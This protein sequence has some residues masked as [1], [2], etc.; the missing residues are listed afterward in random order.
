MARMRPDVR[1][2]LSS[3]SAEHR[4]DD[5]RGDT[6]HAARQA[7][8]RVAKNTRA[9][10]S[11]PIPRTRRREAPRPILP[12]DARRQLVP[13]PQRADGVGTGVAIH[14][15]TKTNATRS[16]PKRRDGPGARQL[17]QGHQRL[18]E[19]HV[20]WPNASRFAERLAAIA[21]SSTVIVAKT[22]S[23]R[24][25][26][27]TATCRTRATAARAPTRA[28]TRAAA[29]L[30]E[31]C[32]GTRAAAA[33]ARSDEQERNRIPRDGVIAKTAGKKAAPDERT[34]PGTL[35]EGAMRP[36]SAAAPAV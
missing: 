4:Q 14:V 24:P 17:A 27:S 33:T 11:P 10:S 31:A 23:V 35:G 7:C 1:V 8:Q 32:A 12:R 18:A 15:V 28:V 20:H 9:V 13:S 29:S 22:T 26:P 6:A 19:R 36:G 30:A 34:Q 2:A 5:E 16:A 25:N 21:R 3:D